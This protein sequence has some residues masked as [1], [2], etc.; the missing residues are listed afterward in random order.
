MTGTDPYA[1]EILGHLEVATTKIRDVSPPGHRRHVVP[2]LRPPRPA[3][4]MRVFLAGATG[5]I[6]ARSCRSY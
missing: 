3:D 2:R 1:G 6:G 5:V 4:A